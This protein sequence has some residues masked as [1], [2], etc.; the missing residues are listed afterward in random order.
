MVAAGGV[1]AQTDTNYTRINKR[2]PVTNS[3]ELSPPLVWS[4]IHECAQAVLVSGFIP[5]ADLDVYADG[6]HHV[7]HLDNA[8]LGPQGEGAVVH[9]SRPLVRNE[10]ITATQTVGNF[11]SVQSY[12][13]VLVTPYDVTTLPKPVVSH[14]IYSCGQIVPVD[15]LEPSAYV[16]VSDGANPIG[17]DET[18]GTSDPV[19]TTPL[20]A[21]HKITAQQVACP[22]DPPLKLTGP[23]SLAV[24]V[25]P[26]PNPV[27]APTVDPVIPGND[28]VQL[29]NLYVGAYVEVTDHGSVIGNGFATAKDNYCQV[30][31][32][33]AHPVIQARQTLCTSSKFSPPQTNTVSLNK[34]T[35]VAP[36]CDHSR[37]VTI[38]GSQVGATVVLERNGAIIGYGGAVPGDLELAIGGGQALNT[39]DTLTAYQYAGSTIS[40][41]S[42]AVVVGGCSEAVTYHNNNARTGLNP[43]ETILTPSNV[44][45]EG[46]GLLFTHPVDGQVYGQPLV[47]SQVAIPNGGVHN[48]VYVVTENDS[49]YAFDSDSV[50]GPYN[51]DPLW[52][53]SFTNQA[54]QLTS[55]PNGDVDTDDINPKIGITSTPVIDL[56]TRTIYVEAKTKE[57]TNG[58]YHYVHKLHALDLGSGAE[59]YGGPVVIAETVTDNVSTTYIS[60]PSVNGSGDG[61]VGNVV[62]FDALKQMNRPGLLLLNGI[63]YIAFASHGDNNPYHGWLLA[64]DAHSLKLV[65]VLNTTPNGSRGGI[66]E[67]GDGPAADS[68]GSIYVAT[69]NGAFDSLNGQGWPASGDFGDSILK[70][71]PDP[72]STQSQPNQNGWGFKIVD[73]FT[74]WN[75]SDLDN[76]DTDL[77]SGGL[78]ILPDQS[79][80]P[81]HLLVHCGKKG[82]IYLVNRDNLGKSHSGS[83]NDQVVQ[84]IPGGIAGSWT[85]PAFMSNIVYY[86][87]AVDG[88]SCD[89]L[90]SFTLA[91]NPSNLTPGAKGS[92]SECFPGSTPSISGAV[93]TAVI[94]TL[95]TDQFRN[96]PAVLHAYRVRGLAEIY[97]ST[98]AGNKRDQPPGNAVKFTVPTVVNGKVYVGTSDHLVVYGLLH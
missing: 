4:P 28:S 40:P 90:K 8:W 54:V 80:G 20:V 83:G 11:T 48:V 88:G 51:A 74:P 77:G 30:S 81:K 34:L 24:R 62:T 73:Y 22:N 59:K 14:T 49:V 50:A 87:G 13:P 18:T 25:L 89:V 45:P 96:G 55:V 61:A 52:H 42:A 70:V 17:Q 78:I 15:Q 35:I 43:N 76:N 9:L 12:V 58:Q 7:G 69:G 65:G 71:E 94:W 66:W 36:V 31:P 3:D 21:G 67:A 5:S 38:G 19:L 75:Q 95:Q 91:G 97:N 29:H 27:L 98:M 47:V 39:G 46:F 23:N 84:E 41:A 57:V 60:G 33:S 82:T 92:V 26:S 64:F 72:S 68:G 1:S 6:S 16:T 79:S 56:N 63:V 53:V 32:I 93:K 2:F 10:K 86:H 37:F 85:T 44:N